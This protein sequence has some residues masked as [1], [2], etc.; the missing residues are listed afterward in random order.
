MFLKLEIAYGNVF[1]FIIFVAL[2]DD[3][4]TRIEILMQ[5]YAVDFCAFSNEII[6]LVCLGG[7]FVG[8]IEFFKGY[9]H[10]P[11]DNWIKLVLSVLTQQNSIK[12]L[13]LL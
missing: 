3:A 8:I 10:F 12:I 13:H 7:V 2:F 11:R 5:K 6:L 9:L 1:N 4:V